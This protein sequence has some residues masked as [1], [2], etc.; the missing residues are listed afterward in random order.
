MSPSPDGIPEAVWLT[1]PTVVRCL[2]LAQL[3][4]IEQ[5]RSQLTA[6]ATE[7]AQLRERIGRSSR[8]SS[9]PPSSGPGFKPPDRSKGGSGRKRGG[10]PGHP[11]SAPELLPIERA[12]EVVEHQGAFR[13]RQL[14]YVDALVMIHA[15]VEGRPHEGDAVAPAARR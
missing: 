11:V 2:I 12:D 5:L 13:H 3:R 8:N 7:P 10:Q 15:L 9:K 14:G 1:T 4:E 6:L